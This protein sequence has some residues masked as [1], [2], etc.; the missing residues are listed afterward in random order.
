MMILLGINES[1]SGRSALTQQNAPP[2]FFSQGTGQRVAVSEPSEALL[3]KLRKFIDV[4]RFAFFSQ[5]FKTQINERLTSF[6]TPMCKDRLAVRL[7][8]KLPYSSK[9]VFKLKFKDLKDYLL[10]ILF[11]HNR[12]LLEVKM[13]IYV[14]I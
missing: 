4:Q 8:L 1:E 3:Q 12:M 7:S 14:G 11:F 2:G 10:D 9:L 5:Y 6:S 13:K